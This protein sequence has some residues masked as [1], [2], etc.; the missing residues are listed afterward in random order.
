MP[1]A[2]VQQQ[3]QIE[4]IQEGVIILKGGGLRAVLLTTSVNFSLK[5]TEEQDALIY[6]Y[7]GFINSLDFPIQILVIS[8]QLDISAYLTALEQR[9]KEQPNEL[10]RI[11]IAEYTDFIKNLVQM[12]NI[13]SQTFLV[14]VPLAPVEKKEGGFI[15]KLGLF[16]KSNNQNENKSLEELKVQLWQRVEYVMAGLNG[17][18][19]K[20]APLNNQEITE[21]FYHLYNMGLKEKPTFEVGQE[22]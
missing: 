11:Q 9:R 3:I 7:Q 1:Q 4:D 20:A 2:P 12:S 10:L 15:A 8:R 5:S 22:K 18:G 13:M 21:L 16:Q 6:K 14:V 17:L 19:I